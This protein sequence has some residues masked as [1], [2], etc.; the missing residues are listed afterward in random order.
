MQKSNPKKP[1]FKEQAQPVP[2]LDK[3]MDPQPE[4]DDDSVGSNKL[5]NKKCIIT[6]GD[7]GIGRAVTIAFAK[8]GAD[9]A[10]IHLPDE[11][12]DAEFTAGYVRKNFGRDC[13][14][15]ATDISKE[16]NCKT[17]VQKVLK[18]FKK[19]DILIN[20]AAVQHIAGDITE[21]STENLINTFSVN[22][23]SMFWITSAVL[24]HMENGGCI[25]NTTS[26]TAY[27]GSP[28]LIDY[29]SSKGAIVSFTRSLAS[30]LIDRGIRVNGVAPGPV[31]T[32][33]IAASFPPDEV[34]KFGTDSPM[35]RPAQPKEL[36]PAYVFLASQDSSFISGQIIH[37][38]GGEIVNG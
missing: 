16:K 9:V 6:G 20:N 37:V 25:I 14:L 24:P 23:F 30:N 3:K 13:L 2:G 38:N 29:S 22:I 11:K 26:V 21:I 19:I 17:A 5:H 33:L 4:F 7:S 35:K 27:R 18:S 31:W 34:A 12:E 8:Q 36:A 15:V 28:R 32:P 1:I 10:I